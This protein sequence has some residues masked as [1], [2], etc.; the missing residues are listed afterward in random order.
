VW[1]ISVTIYI[2]A[3]DLSVIYVGETVGR[4]GRGVVLYS[5]NIIYVRILNVCT[6]SLIYSVYENNS[7]QNKEKE[8]TPNERSSPPHILEQQSRS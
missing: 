5:R 1:Y 3:A 4:L 7:R 8:E 6:S 2:F